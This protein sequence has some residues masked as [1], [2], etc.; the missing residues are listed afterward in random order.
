MISH[1][2]Q[3]IYIHIPKCAGRS[4]CQ[5]FNQ[6]FDHHTAAYYHTAHPCSWS[7]YTVFTTVRNPYQRL[8]SMYH[9]IQNEPVHANHAITNFGKMLPFKSWVMANMDCFKGEFDLLSTEGNREDHGD[10]GSAFWFSSQVSRLSTA[11]QTDFSNIHILR[12]EDGMKAVEDFVHRKTGKP[13]N[14]QHLN[15]SHKDSHNSYLNYYDTELLN[16]VNAFPPFIKDCTLL[17]YQVIK[18][19]P[20]V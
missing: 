15:R 18:E 7:Q 4:I 12:Y 1:H 19:V 9:Y 16:T 20:Q 3:V 17:Q 6:D 5:A 14:I 2:H 11:L 8:V 13:I 10:L